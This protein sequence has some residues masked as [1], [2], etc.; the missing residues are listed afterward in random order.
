M[1]APGGPKTLVS[2]VVIAKRVGELAAQISRD[3]ASADEVVLVGVLKGAFIFMADLARRLTIPRRVE[4]IAVSSYGAGARR[5][6]EVA[7]R[8]DI[9]L[10]GEHETV[11]FDI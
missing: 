4:F 11:F 3:Y 10:Q 2:E 7:Y 1:K 6:G 9:R 5:T 8:F